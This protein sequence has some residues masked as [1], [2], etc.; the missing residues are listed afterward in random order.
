VNPDTYTCEACNQ[1][2]EK[3]R[4]DDEAMA[5]SKQ[6][7]GDI[8]PEDQAVICES[9]FR[10]FTKWWKSLSD[11]ERADLQRERKARA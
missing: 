9:C 2:F 11:A 6:M 1:V 5:E 7:W 4:S 8:P 3:G 10:E